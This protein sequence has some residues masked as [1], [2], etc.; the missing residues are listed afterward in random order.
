MRDGQE[1]LQ[2]IRATGTFKLWLHNGMVT[3]Y[4]VKLEGTLSVQLPTGRREIQ[5]SQ[6]T[7]TILKD[8]GTTKFEIPPQ[9]RKK[10]GV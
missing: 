10:L 7:D 3:K 6:I 8:V 2:P 5:V 1:N 9:A 4:Q